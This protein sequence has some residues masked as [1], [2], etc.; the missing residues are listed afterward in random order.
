MTLSVLIVDDTVRWRDIVRLCC[1]IDDRFAVAAEAGNGQEAVAQARAVH[2]DVI[3]LD[4]DMPVQSGLQAL[5]PLRDVA[6]DAAIVAFSSS[7]RSTS[8][9]E[10]LE[11]GAD[12]YVEK[13][14]AVP[15]LL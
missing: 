6:P 8:E 4:L 15:S 14:D 5:P 3:V 9:R 11:L 13:G 10:A 2:P 1:E 7:T 12:A